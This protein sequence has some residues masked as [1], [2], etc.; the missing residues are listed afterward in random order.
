MYLKDDDEGYLN[1]LDEK[2]VT[3]TT[4]TEQV[5]TWVPLQQI[6]N[7]A[8]QVKRNQVLPAPSSPPVNHPLT[9][10]Q[11]QGLLAVPVFP[12]LDLNA[13]T[14]IIQ[15]AD[16]LDTP[17]SLPHLTALYNSSQMPK[18]GRKQRPLPF[19]DTEHYLR[20]VLHVKT[21]KIIDVIALFTKD[22]RRKPDSIRK[23]LYRG[24]FSAL[25]FLCPHTYR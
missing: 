25:M 14:E 24:T 5:A 12:N 22:Y 2:D 1:D 4:N 16:V 20:I 11:I 17:G 13:R 7:Q 18:S 3:Q 10:E 23:Q 19:T 21:S 8:G 9:A 15:Y 6:Q